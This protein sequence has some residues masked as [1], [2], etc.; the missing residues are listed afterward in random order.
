MRKKNHANRSKAGARRSLLEAVLGKDLSEGSPSAL[1]AARFIGNMSPE[2]AAASMGISTAAWERRE[3]GDA[4]FSRQFL[5][6]FCEKHEIPDLSWCRSEEELD[7]CER[8]RVSKVLSANR[9][10]VLFLINNQGF[11]RARIE[12]TITIFELPDA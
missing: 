2:T 12:M 10:D 7:C 6:E 3:L 8:E 11:V 4:V 5:K 9:R 1:K